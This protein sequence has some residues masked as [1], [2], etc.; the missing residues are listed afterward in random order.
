MTV[1][2]ISSSIS[3]KEYNADPAG[4]EPATPVHQSDAHLSEPA[5][6]FVCFRGDI[7]KIFTRFG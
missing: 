3:M 5:R 1:V 2:N 6:P 4:V 7:K